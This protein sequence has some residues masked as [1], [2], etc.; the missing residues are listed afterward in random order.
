MPQIDAPQ[1]VSAAELRGDAHPTL[2]E[3]ID[4]VA[5]FMRR[6]YRIILLGVIA[7]LPLG[8]LYHY[9]TPASYTASTTVVLETQR[10]LLQES[11]L[12]HATTDASWIES[13]IGVLKS[14]NVAAY[15]V[16]QLRLAEDPVFTGIGS[17]PTF[18]D[19]VLA[20]LGWASIESKTEAERAGA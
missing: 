12:G 20:R 13:Q 4:I 11:I 3:R 8:A 18:I 5:S 15:V 9:V 1:S 2:S 7:C 14:Q 6:R 16:K 17:G 10:G 19:K